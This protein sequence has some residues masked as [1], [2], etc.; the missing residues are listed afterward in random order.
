MP[1]VLE[2]ML[3][4]CR[5]TDV[6]QMEIMES[7]DADLVDERQNAQQEEDSGDEYEVE[8]GS[9][10]TTLRKSAAYAL[11]AFSKSF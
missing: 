9:A 10:N 6:D 8:S 11:G 1:E 4:C 5:I 3:L 2:Q 7:R